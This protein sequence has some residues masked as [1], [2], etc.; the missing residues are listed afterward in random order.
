M[1]YNG[2]IWIRMGSYGD[3]TIKKGK[4]GGIW[5]YHCDLMGVNGNGI[6]ATI[7]L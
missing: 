2:I 5:G 7:K 4:H 6:G 3:L 1:D